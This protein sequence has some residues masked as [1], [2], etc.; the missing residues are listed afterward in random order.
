[1]AKK[2][3][4]NKPSLGEPVT[5]RQRNSGHVISS[6]G[7]I[8]ACIPQLAGDGPLQLFLVAADSL[9]SSM[10]RQPKPIDLI[11]QLRQRELT[12]AARSPIAFSLGLMWSGNRDFQ[13]SFPLLSWAYQFL[14]IIYAITEERTLGDTA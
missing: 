12:F 2:W 13:C 9:R 8:Y 14:S 1:M 7:S 10:D 6:L 5:W 11:G 4:G 3:Q